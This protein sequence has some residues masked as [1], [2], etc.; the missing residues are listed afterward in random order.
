MDWLGIDSLSSQDNDPCCFGSGR[1][2]SG[3]STPF[4]KDGKQRDH[5]GEQGEGGAKQSGNGL[6]QGVA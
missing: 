2:A 1:A 4:P 6:S 5:E 3:F